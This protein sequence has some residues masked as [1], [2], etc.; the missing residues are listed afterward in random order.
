MTQKHAFTC[1]RHNLSA[2]CEWI[3]LTH[4]NADGNLQNPLV[5]ER[6]LLRDCAIS[7]L[8]LSVSHFHLLSSEVTT[9]L[10]NSL[11]LL[12]F[13]SDLFALIAL[14]GLPP[15]TLHDKIVGRGPL[16]LYYRGP[17]L[18]PVQTQHSWVRGR[19]RKISYQSSNMGAQGWVE[20][21]P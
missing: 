5:R 20:W 16:T 1:W 17:L 21:R 2:L 13:A 9:Q 8:L 3:Y 4:T 11:E 10:N 14:S 12:K 18:F 6:T 7:L 19:G 15:L